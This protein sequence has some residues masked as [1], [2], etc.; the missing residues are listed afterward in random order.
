MELEVVSEQ[1]K[2]VLEMQVEEE[3]ALELVSKMN[4]PA[5]NRLHILCRNLETSCNFYMGMCILQRKPHLC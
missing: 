4:H 2:V 1:L 3:E 5:Y